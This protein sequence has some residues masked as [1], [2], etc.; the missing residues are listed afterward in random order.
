MLFRSLDYFDA[1]INR[2]AA[3]AVGIRSWERALLTALCT[4]S[5]MLKKLQDENKLTELMVRHEEVRMLP[6]GDIWDEYCTR[7]G[8]PKDGEWFGEVEKYEKDVLLKR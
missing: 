5:E 1:S 2:V 7:C 8:A 3:W 4:P 6:W